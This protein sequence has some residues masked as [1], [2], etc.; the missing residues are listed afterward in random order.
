[1]SVDRS[2]PRPGLRRWVAVN[3]ATGERSAWMESWVSIHHDGSVTLATAI[4]AHFQGRDAYHE[5][6]Q[7]RSSAVECA[8][9]DFMALIRTTARATGN[10]E[11]DVRAGV[12]WTGEQPLTIL[13][14]DTMG[15]SYNGV[16]T[17]LHRY[18]PV[19]TT[20]NAAGPDLDYHGNVRDLALDC[21]NQ[22]GISNL[23][24]IWAE[25]RSDQA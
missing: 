10:D 23:R 21:L 6:W 11:Y 17:P 7:I 18:T 25:P 5:G 16:S 19:E 22:G 14:V 24:M 1:M 12:S 20:V 2:N 9:A 4:G 13:T 15:F 8:I 3:T